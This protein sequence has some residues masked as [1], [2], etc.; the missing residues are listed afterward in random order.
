MIAYFVIIATCGGECAILF[1][2]RTN[3]GGSQTTVDEVMELAGY[4][5]RLSPLIIAF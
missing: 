3:D 1:F 5:E 4:R 2:P